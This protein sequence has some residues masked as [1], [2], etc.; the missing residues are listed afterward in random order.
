[1][2]EPTVDAVKRDD[3][4]EFLDADRTFHLV[5]LRLNGSDELVE[6]DERLRARSRL[7]DAG[8]KAAC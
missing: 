8:S 7:A 6:I 1:L 2:A 4:P 5:L 3:I